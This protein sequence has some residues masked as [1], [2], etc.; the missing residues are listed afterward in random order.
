MIKKE[1]PEIWIVLKEELKQALILPVV[2][3]TFKEKIEKEIVELREELAKLLNDKL[4]AHTSVDD[5]SDKIAFITGK[6]EGL[7]SALN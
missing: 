6:I 4:S 1:K 5:W 7:K 2:G 3:I